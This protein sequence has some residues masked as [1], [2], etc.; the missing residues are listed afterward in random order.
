M[1]LIERRDHRYRRVEEDFPSITI[2]LGSHRK[3][4]TGPIRSVPHQT[5]L[6][7][8][9]EYEVQAANILT[10]VELPPYRERDGARR[11]KAARAIIVALKI[12]VV[13][14]FFATLA[15]LLLSL[16]FVRV[17]A[18]QW[19]IASAAAAIIFGGLLVVGVKLFVDLRGVT[20]GFTTISFRN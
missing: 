20:R 14:L 19:G 5:M 8:E 17:D 2:A 3:R 16:Y 7:E 6:G 13:V 4:E 18:D 12:L 9:F 1:A 15:C 10:G 11:Y